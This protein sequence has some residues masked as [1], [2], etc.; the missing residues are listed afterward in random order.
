M[1]SSTI[2][3]KNR[4]VPFRG[5][6]V[7][8]AFKEGGMSGTLVTDNAGKATINHIGSGS[9]E[10]IVN[11]QTSATITVPSTSNVEI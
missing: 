8:L 11:G 10:V 5:A 3:I 6:R 1:S 7:T 9:A 2:Y 4:G